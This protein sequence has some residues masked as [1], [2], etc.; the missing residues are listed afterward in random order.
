MSVQIVIPPPSAGLARCRCGFRPHH[1]A[2]LGRG[3]AQNAVGSIAGHGVRHRIECCRCG[4]Q[5]PEQASLRQCEQ[6]WGRP[7]QQH[8]L[9]LPTRKAA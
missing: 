7:N 6:V 3:N 1:I 4:R 5:T 9:P 2:I 8:R